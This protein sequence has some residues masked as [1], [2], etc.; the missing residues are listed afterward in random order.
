[1]QLGQFDSGSATDWRLTISDEARL[2]TD[3]EIALILREAAQSADSPAEP[4]A[5]SSGLSLAQIKAGAAEAGL[6][7]ALVERAA[8]R[9][10]QRGSESFF[11]RLAG[12]PRR[13][14]ET[15]SVPVA[16]S[17]EVSTRLLSAIRAA[18][19]VPGEGRADASGFSWY[20]WYRSGRLSVTA[21]EDS[22][23]TRIQIL[24]D[25]TSSMVMT[26]IWTLFAVVLP[27]WMLVPS[28]NSVP[29]VLLALA[30]LPIGVLAAAR[31][32]WKSS[33]RSVRERIAVL[34][35]AVRKSL[36]TGGDEGGRA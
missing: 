2:Y 14:R 32:Y 31:W 33:T 7:P 5:P 28:I 36:P 23:G 20:A 16:M 10:S 19:E 35:E 11:E 29:D 18:A 34:L 9:L 26:L 30:V 4:R 22:R 6:D 12:G 1:M 27:A 15:I 17:E 25:R 3:Q 24:V 13:H 8:L 21:H